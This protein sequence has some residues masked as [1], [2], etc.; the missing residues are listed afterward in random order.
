MKVLITGVCGFVGSSIARSLIERREG[1]EIFGV[2]NFS[3]SG[4]ETNRSKLFARGVQIRHADVR[5]PSDL[6]D[7]P[8]VDWIVDA[9]ANPSVL[10]GTATGCTSRQVIETNL[11]GTVNLLELAKRFEAGFVLLSSSRVYSVRALAELPVEAHDNAFQPILETPVEGVSDRG[12]AETFSTAPPVSLYGSSKAASEIVAL[13]YGDAFSFPV[14]VNRCGVIGGAGQFGRA[15]QGIFAYWINAYLRGK[16]LRYIGFGGSGFQV[17]DC[18]HPADLTALIDL[19]FAKPANQNDRLLNIGGGPLRAMSLAQLTAWA[20][21]R[22]GPRDIGK[23][24]DER[25]YDAPWIVMD[26]K[27]ATELYGWQQSVSLEN[28]LAEIA[29]HAAENPDWLALSD[30][31]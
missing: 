21:Q 7:L 15:D 24:M 4:S 2:D 31:S 13:E 19:Q 1:I 28:N 12:I 18:L 9:A 8:R 25:R 11:L 16:Q 17:R 23:S 20:A 29:Q 26:S 5:L 3:R 30:A 10:A 6:D 27:R 22:F 14:L